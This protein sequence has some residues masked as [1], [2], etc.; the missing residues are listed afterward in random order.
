[1]TIAFQEFDFRERKKNV[2]KKMNCCSFSSTQLMQQGSVLSISNNYY[3]NFKV[4]CHEEKKLAE[5]DIGRQ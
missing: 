4:L 2:K 5:T 1:M 3:T